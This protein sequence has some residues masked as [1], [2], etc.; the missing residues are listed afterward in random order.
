[1]CRL[2][3]VSALLLA[4]TLTPTAAT[5]PRLLVIVVVDQMR[6]DYLE[7]FGRHWQH[8]FKTLLERG[9]L[10]DRAA[11]PY[12]NTATCAGH[13]TIATGTLPR[14]HGMILN[15]WWDRVERRSIE[16]TDDRDSPDVTYGRPVRLANSAKRQ[17]APSLADEL[18]AQQPGSRTVAVSLKARSAIPLGGRT[19]DAVVWFDDGAGSFV[20]AKAFAAEPV[21]AVKAFLD[22]S[23]FE[24]DLGREW[25]LFGSRDSYLQ[26]DAGIEERP[27]APWTG[28]FPHQV[29]APDGK[30]DATFFD[31]WQTSPF[32]DAYLARMALALADDFALGRRDVTDVL[33]IGFSALDEVGHDFGPRSR[34]V[35]DLLRHL[36]VTLGRLIEGLDARVGRDRYVLA[37]SADHGI[38]PLPVAG[39][40][41]R[42]VS[43]DVRE[44][45]EE[46]LS[47]AFGPLAAGSYVDA[48]PSG[49]VYLAPGVFDRLR[50]APAVMRRVMASV[51][52]I[53]G[54]SRV[55]RRDELS[56]ASGDPV[57]QAAALGHHGDRSGDL[58]VVPRRGWF[59]NGRRA[60]NATTHGSPYDYDT[61]VPV[62][63]FGGEVAPGRSSVAASPADIAPTL[64]QFAGI[65][66]P[67]AEGRALPVTVP[68]H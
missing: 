40:T 26:A 61:R 15:T 46:T 41:G 53:P 42:V 1:M 25:A 54:V 67:K 28:L 22:A 3:V 12:L 6:A 49:Y 56:A 21:P 60:T 63:F 29:G 37:L 23:P 55:L 20:T 18:R 57:V 45:I 51:R 8:G 44:R 58:I 38:P 16:C 31:L 33:G 19:P 52:Q 24:R 50:A 39:V 35:E 13:T 47:A 30:P 36:D 59:V 65:R 14:T 66:M 17:L 5:P 62:I 43:E 68:V 32:S 10:F 9:R 34:E 4:T 2:F 27:P 64:A 11:Y 48:A 7:Q